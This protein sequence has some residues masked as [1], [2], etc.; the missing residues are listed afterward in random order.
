MHITHLKSHLALC[1][2]LHTSLPVG[3][4]VDSYVSNNILCLSN[5][6]FGGI[7][8]II[9]IQP[10]Q[11]D[12]QQ[13]VVYCEIN[14]K[15]EYDTSK[16]DDEK[17]CF[18]W[19]V[20]QYEDTNYDYFR[21][22]VQEK[23]KYDPSLPSY[24]CLLQPMIALCR[25]TILNIDK[26][27]TVEQSFLAKLNFEIR[28]RGISIL[29]DSAFVLQF[30][31]ILD[32]QRHIKLLR[33]QDEE[34]LNSFHS[35]SNSGIIPEYHDFTYKIVIKGKFSEQLELQQFPIDTQELNITLTCNKPHIIQ[36]LPNQEFPSIFMYNDFQLK[37]I[38][39]VSFREYV[40]S[41]SELSNAKESSS[42]YQYPRFR[43]VMYLTRK[44]GYYMSN[45]CIPIMIISALSLISC[46]INEDGTRLQTSDRLGITLTLLLTGVA[47][48]FVVASSLPQLSYLTLLDSYVWCCFGFMFLIAVENVLFPIVYFHGTRQ[49]INY[50]LVEPYLTLILGLIFVGTNLGWIGYI[51]YVIHTRKQNIRQKFLAEKALRKHGFE[52]R[53]FNMTKSTE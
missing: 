22:I 36:I 25:G 1:V 43:F 5:T 13:Q 49:G 2:T 3:Y 31:Q 24:A 7:W 48:K 27:D 4:T 14:R 34:V 17:Y 29:N 51:Y 10:Y 37:S 50:D 20:Q 21:T 16:G 53:Q 39:D 18:G 45:V 52:Q 32:I 41:V 33:I 15:V 40:F 12:L 46:G 19:E 11:E 30:M 35:Y 42:G 26:I 38:Y 47:Y 23:V 6:Q 8:R 28:F 9:Q 44:S